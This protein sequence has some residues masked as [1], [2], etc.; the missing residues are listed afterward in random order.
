M[1]RTFSK[2]TSS[3]VRH[4]PLWADSQAK[5]QPGPSGFHSHSSSHLQIYL[6]GC[7]RYTSNLTC[8]PD[9][10]SSLTFYSPQHVLTFLAVPFA[11]FLTVLP[12]SSAQW[13]CTENSPVGAIG[14]FSQ[15]R[16]RKSLGVPFGVGEFSKPCSPMSQAANKTMVPI[17]ELQ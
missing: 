11:S 16:V 13:V 8:A 2:V 6:H 10:I 14:G 9:N 7:P 17:T 1:P 15:H 4:P 5:V 3:K 12:T